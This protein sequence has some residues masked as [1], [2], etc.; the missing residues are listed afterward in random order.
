[1]DQSLPN[2][3]SIYRS[4]V[5]SPRTYMVVIVAAVLG[6]MAKAVIP[7]SR[8]D[9]A[10]GIVEILKPGVQS[11]V[12]VWAFVGFAALVAT[13]CACLFRRRWA[14]AGVAL[15]VALL[16][17]PACLFVA[18]VLNLGPWTIYASVTGPDHQTYSFLDS[19]FL[20]G[21]TM[22]I[23]RLEGDGLLYQRYHIP[24]TTN[25]DSPR[26]W[27]SIIRPAEAAEQYG[28]LYCTASGLLVGVRLE[29]QCYLTFDPVSGEFL[30]HGAVEAISPFVLLGPEG[31]PHQRDVERIRDR[32]R[33]GEP[34]RPGYPQEHW[35]RQA[36]G[37]P[38]PEVRRVAKQLLEEIRANPSRPQHP[39]SRD[40]HNI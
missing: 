34:D 16:G 36:L 7:M 3:R 39:V 33:K 13:A 5:F 17:Y 2:A 14:A 6:F 19:S 1:M 38:N 37:H 24:G 30:G 8:H 18:A 20:Q 12:N 35:V 4:V 26:S 29:N 32:I 22:A 15:I 10:A 31:A 27:A 40:Q 21:Q 23:G 11:A 25:G 9:S 28:Q